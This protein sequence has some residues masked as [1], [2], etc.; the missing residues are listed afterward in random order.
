MTW[1]HNATKAAVI[2]LVRAVALDVAA[3]G[4]RVTRSA[5]GLLGGRGGVDEDGGAASVEFR[6]QGLE[7][8]A[9]D[10]ARPPRRPSAPGCGIR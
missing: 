9:S 4:I 8:G 2:N 1:P 5:P 7:A 3:A 10:T 6:E